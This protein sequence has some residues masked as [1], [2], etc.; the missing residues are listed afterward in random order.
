MEN[1][2]YSKASAK[3]KCKCKLEEIQNQIQ[4]EQALDER[5][6]ELDRR[7]QEALRERERMTRSL[8]L[9][10]RLRKVQRELE[11][12]RLITSFTGDAGMT[13]EYPP[14]PPVTSSVNDPPQVLAPFSMSPRVLYP[15]EPLELF[16]EQQAPPAGPR[17]SPSYPVPAGQR[18][19][20]PFQRLPPAV[21]QAA[22]TTKSHPVV[23][24]S[25]PEHAA[26]SPP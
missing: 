15:A 24:T 21:G 6:Q 11:E 10:R 7:A 3:C 12:A 2:I 1:N 16:S 14:A 25:S 4:E 18:P 8:T 17:I 20:S 13:T 19:P 9:Q 23:R 26:P 5:A 22:T